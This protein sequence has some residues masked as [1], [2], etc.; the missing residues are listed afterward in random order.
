MGSPIK[1]HAGVLRTEK[2][3][4]NGKILHGSKVSSRATKTNVG[5]GK[6]KRGRNFRRKQVSNNTRMGSSHAKL[7]LWGKNNVKK[8]TINILVEV[9]I[10]GKTLL[11]NA[12]IWLKIWH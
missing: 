8:G 9:G 7:G 4:T 11:K 10:L 6:K 5:K 12:F 2:K 3:V 1:F